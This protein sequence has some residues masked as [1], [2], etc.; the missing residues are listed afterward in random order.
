M[1]SLLSAQNNPH[2]KVAH[3]GVT[4]FASPQC[5]QGSPVP[6]PGS[7][8]DLWCVSQRAKENERE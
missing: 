6:S 4:Y 7:P 5:S 3:F 2:S 8:K 1:S